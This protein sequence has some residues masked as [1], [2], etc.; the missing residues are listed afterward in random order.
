MLKRGFFLCLIVL[1]NLSVNA[2]DASEKL[3]RQHS[4][5]KGGVRIGL[6]CSQISGDD[7]AGY[8]Q[9]GVYTGLYVTFPMTQNWKW[10]VQPELNFNMKGSRTFFPKGLTEGQ[11]TYSLRLCYIE[12]PAVFK[13]NFF[14]GFILEFGPSFNINVLHQEK[15][16][17]D[18]DHHVQ[19]FRWY[20]FAGLVGLSYIFKGHYAIF[21]RYTGSIIPVR[22]PNNVMNRLQKKQFNDAMM[23]GFYY[24]F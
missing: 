18:I 10:M 1:L 21:Y 12:I 4:N 2:Q 16:D 14:K 19:A 22:V 5:V 7:L 8:H 3:S 23:F 20:E 6:T 17:G 24:Q 13:W 11:Q 9:L 15:F